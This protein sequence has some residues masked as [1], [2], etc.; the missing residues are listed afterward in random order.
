MK[1]L[2]HLKEMG[3]VKAPPDFEMACMEALT[4]GKKRVRRQKYIHLS[5]A[6]AFSGMLI[7]ALVVGVFVLPR[8]GQID[9]SS[10]EK[11]VTSDF[12]RESRLRN[13]NTIPIT[14]P[15]GYVQEM[16]NFSRE[17]PTVYILEQ[18][19]DQTDTKIKY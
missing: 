10:L 14:E 16:R 6:S 1:E 19:S 9:L 13:L 15:V 12:M 4:K 18:V 11:G 2:S 3:R 8:R 5:L 17:A 7:V